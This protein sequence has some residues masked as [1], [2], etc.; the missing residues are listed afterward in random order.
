MVILRLRNSKLCLAFVL[1]VI[2]LTVVCVGMIAARVQPINKVAIIIDSSGSFRSRYNE[3]V[4][5]AVEQLNGISQVKVQRWETASAEIVLISLDAIPEVIWKGSAI[6]LKEHGASFW[7]SRFRARRDY[8]ACTDVSGAFRVAARHLSGDSHYVHKYVFAFSDL[9]SEPPGNSIYRPRT[10]SNEPR[11]DFPWKL[12]REVS[13]SIFWVP[14][15]QKLLWQRAAQEHGLS[16]FTLYTPL[17]SAEVAIQPPPRPKREYTEAERRTAR[18]RY[19]RYWKYLIAVIGF[20]VAAMLALLVVTGLLL[21]RRRNHL[22][23]RPE[24]HESQS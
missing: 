13:V 4:Q 9:I 8:S 17:E 20:F 6:E 15:N 22:R 23:V 7:T 11:S 14:P 19:I 12:L 2:A 21:R 10:R 24:A 5:K 3:A 18:S 1:V 16:S